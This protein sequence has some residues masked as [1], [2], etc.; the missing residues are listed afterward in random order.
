MH[1]KILISRKELYDLVWA[2]PLKHFP[3]KYMVS[4]SSFKKIC[5]NNNIPIP[6]NGYWSKKKFGKEME[7]PLLEKENDEK[8]IVF[9]LRPEGDNRDFG[10][11]TE[12][13][14]KIIEIES[15]PKT[16]FSIPE[17]ISTSQDAI[18]RETK[19]FLNKEVKIT[20]DLDYYAR[21][22]PGP[23]RCWVMKEE[24]RRAL[25]IIS[26]LLKNLK[27]RGHEFAFGRF[28]SF[29]KLFGI[30]IQFQLSEKNKKIKFQGK[31]GEDY[32][33]EATGNFTIQAGPNYSCKVWNDGKILKLEE[34]ISEI[35][36]W[37]EMEAEKERLWE[38]ESRKR[39]AEREEKER[40]ERERQEL[41]NR[42]IKAF[43]ELYHKSELWH[44]AQKFRTYLKHFEDHL[45]DKNQLTKENIELLEFG[46]EKADWMDPLSPV[47][48]EVLGDLNLSDINK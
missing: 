29:I 33:Y 21:Y 4:Y 26:V 15:D 3:E 5:L 37:L 27:A 34:K 23:I 40:L 18:L 16:N 8:Q 42:E 10:N 36:A 7:I 11:L 39:E 46:H 14:Q 32:R 31:Y 28:G 20:D 9:Y 13:D 48:D 19:K 17:K 1:S 38:I 2:H 6:P 22:Y 47:K 41:L 24:Q 12:L 25:K 44:K 45:I 43:K 30:E 35:I